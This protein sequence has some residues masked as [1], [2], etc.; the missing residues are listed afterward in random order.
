[1][2]LLL[3]FIVFLC[4]IVSSNIS[5]ASVSFWYCFLMFTTHR[6]IMGALFLPWDGH[7]AAWADK[8][9]IALSYRDRSE[10]EGLGAKIMAE[11]AVSSRQASPSWKPKGP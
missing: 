5:A 11:H 8:K 10:N 1:M 6:F 7:L 3:L 2:H 4:C 9:P